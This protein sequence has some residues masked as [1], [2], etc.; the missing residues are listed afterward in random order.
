MGQEQHYCP[1]LPRYSCCY[2]KVSFNWDFFL[3][4]CKRTNGICVTGDVIEG[5]MDFDPES[6]GLS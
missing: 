1:R 2:G 4:K 6:L 5:A 3:E